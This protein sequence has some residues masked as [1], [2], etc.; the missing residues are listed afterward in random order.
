MS[1]ADEVLDLD[2]E[3]PLESLFG[4]LASPLC[5]GITSLA[6]WFFFVSPGKH[7]APPIW[8]E[9]PAIPFFLMMACLWA[10]GQWLLTNY[11]VRYQLDPKTQQLNLVRKIFGQTFRSRVAEFSQLYSTAVMSTWSDDKHGNRSWEYAMCLVTNSARMVRVSSYSSTAPNAEADRIAKKL[12]ISHFPCQEQTGTL[13]ATRGRQG[14]VTLRY[15]APAS[16]A[17]T[18]LTSFLI[19]LVAVGVILGLAAWL[20]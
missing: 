14:K 20:M 15:R 10:L 19:I 2:Y 7:G 12:G 4:F 16:K 5:M 9:F 1:H 17:M 6:T 18:A 3:S 13:Q 8:A 11:D